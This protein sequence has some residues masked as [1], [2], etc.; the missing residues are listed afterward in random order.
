M[1]PRE[2]YIITLIVFCLT[3]ISFLPLYGQNIPD[4]EFNWKQL[5]KGKALKPIPHYKKAEIDPIC[6]FFSDALKNNLIL[7]FDEILALKKQT[8]TVKIYFIMHVSRSP[9]TTR[10][11]V[12]DLRL[13]EDR[14]FLIADRVNAFPPCLPAK[15][16]GKEVNSEGILYL[17][18]EKGKVIDFYVKRITTDQ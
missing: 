9:L 3:N 13:P 18:I 11:G 16:S 15:Q 7:E 1:K 6:T 17:S 14:Y 8:G 2:I 10:I 4:K 5:E 12:K